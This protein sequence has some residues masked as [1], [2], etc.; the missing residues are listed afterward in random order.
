MVAWSDDFGEQVVILCPPGNHQAALVVL[1]LDIWGHLSTLEQAVAN[2]A[3]GAQPERAAPNIKMVLFLL[4]DSGSIAVRI[5]QTV[6]GFSCWGH[7]TPKVHDKHALRVHPQCAAVSFL[8]S[9][10]IFQV[11]FDVLDEVRN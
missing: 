11:V 8:S 2:A 3:A 5:H 7:H 9:P 1:L 6:R 4:R 10:G